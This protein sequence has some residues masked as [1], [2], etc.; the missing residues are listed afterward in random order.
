MAMLHLLAGPVGASERTLRRAAARGLIRGARPS[1]RRL[2]LAAGE[3]AYLRE[4][5]PLLEQLVETL[6]KHPNVRLA[7]LYGS[8]ARG[9][10]QAE[11]DLDLLVRL[12][13]DDYR[14]RA[15]LAGSLADATGRQVQIVSLAQAEEAPLLLA[16][17]LRDGRVLVDRELDWPRL[18]RR[19]HRIVERA[20]A[21]DERLGALAWAVPD[22]LEQV[23]RKMRGGTRP[24]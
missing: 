16:D 2:V 5:W 24:A 11:S 20:R 8:L 9:D 14:S 12:R 13:R 19:E 4:H 18:R 22:T 21:E 23:R 15:D 3:I 10:E 1:P 7:V 17:V 6:R